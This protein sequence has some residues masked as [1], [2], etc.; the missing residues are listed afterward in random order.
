MR[1]PL[2]A[3]LERE[4]FEKNY[5]DAPPELVA[6]LRQFRV[7]Y[8]YR[9]ATVGGTRWSYIGGG[10]GR[11]LL[12]LTGALGTAESSWQSIAHFARRYRIIAP[13]Y[14]ATISTMADLADGLAGILD[15]AG[16]ARSY[17]MG[18]SFGGYVAQVYV[19]RYVRRT[20]KLVISHAG[21]PDPERGEQIARAM[22]WM[23]LLP[24]SLMRALLKRR[25]GSLLPQERPEGVF[26]AAYL[27]EALRAPGTKER[28]L[29]GFRLAMD[30]D[31][32]QD[33]QAQDLADWPGQV[34]LITADDDPG[35]PPRVREAMMALYPDAKLHLFHGTGHASAILKAEEYNGAVQGFLDE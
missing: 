12:L 19:R 11:P 22:W 32:Q 20:E 25:L 33:F 13:S 35:T 31:L 18:G 7:E 14:P 27:Q 16:V 24:A 10:R 28:F 3:R 30:F 17:V 15:V 23:K 26:M 6:R 9:Q 2:A 21:L 34:L 1:E 29:N 4:D 8:P 5:R